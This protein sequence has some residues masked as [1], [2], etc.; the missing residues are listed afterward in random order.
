M[1][2]YRHEVHW[3]GQIDCT[4]TYT[5]LIS[6][7][8][9]VKSPSW[10]CFCFCYRLLGCF[11]SSLGSCSFVYPGISSACQSSTS[12]ASCS[13]IAS[14]PSSLRE[15][16][17]NK[18]QNTVRKVLRS[19]ARIR[20]YRCTCSTAGLP[21]ATSGSAHLYRSGSRKSSTQPGTFV[22]HASTRV[23]NIG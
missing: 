10:I 8:L 2:I 15:K 1:R 17:K 23:D 9:H 3:T 21:T 20:K 16:N 22:F 5:I 7:V 6:L 11:L 13:S 19:N 18:K 12:T 14:C 4:T